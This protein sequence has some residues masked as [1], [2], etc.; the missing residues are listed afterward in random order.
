MTTTR[1]RKGTNGKRVHYHHEYETPTIPPLQV[2]QPVTI[3]QNTNAKA[4]LWRLGIILASVI[5]GTWYVAT[6]VTAM[7][8]EVRSI[9]T[10]VSEFRES[11]KELSGNLKWLS[12]GTWSRND[13]QAFCRDLE[14]LNSG[15]K[16]RCPT[17]TTGS[18]RSLK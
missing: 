8:Q 1:A 12:G 5:S 2:Q 9:S 10:S 13:M 17:V 16:F 11:V 7:K 4:P 18:S 15:A 6:E 14:Q 3:D